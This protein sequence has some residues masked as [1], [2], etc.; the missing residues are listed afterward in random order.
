M[1][2]TT[3]QKTLRYHRSF[4]FGGGDSILFPVQNYDTL[5]Q[6]FDEVNKADNHM[7]TLK[8]IGSTN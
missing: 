3:D 7:I 8:Q 2:V 1:G 5:K 4:F 6:L